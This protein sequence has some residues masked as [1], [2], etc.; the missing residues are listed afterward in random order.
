MGYKEDVEIDKSSLDYEWLRQASLFMYWGEQ[1]VEAQFLRDKTKERMD[2][3]RAEL[4]SQIRKEPKSFGLGEKVTESA[5]L[6]C[7][8]LH[9]DYKKI[10]EE[11]LENTKTVKTIGVAKE[12][13]EHKKKALEKL[14]DLWI[15]GYWSDPRIKKEA[16]EEVGRFDK[17]SHEKALND[18]SRLQRR[19]RGEET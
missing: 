7:I 11:Y 1:E 10:N 17:E 3:K 12:A 16:K 9:P 2:L 8:L 18:N 5:I 15:S 14:T 19:R 4:D 13:M 6:N